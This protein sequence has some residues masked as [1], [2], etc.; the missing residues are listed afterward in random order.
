MEIGVFSGRDYHT[1]GEIYQDTRRIG[2][3]MVPRADPKVADKKKKE[4][5]KRKPLHLPAT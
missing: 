3:G 1:K 5:K 4:R 2:G